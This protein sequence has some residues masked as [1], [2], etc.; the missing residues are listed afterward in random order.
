MDEL[1]DQFL[2]E[3]REL[4]QQAS[5]DLLALERNPSDAARIDSA[6]RAVHTL[7]GSAGI[8]NFGAMGALLHAAEDLLGAV[9]EGQLAATAEIVGTLIDC[10]IASENWI[11]SIENRGELPTDAHVVGRRLRGAMAPHLERVGLIEVA[12]PDTDTGWAQTLIARN[13]K[14]AHAA[15]GA[16]TALR[17]VPAKDCFFLGDD[18]LAM[19]RAIPDLVALDILT[20]EAWITDNF[21]PFVCNLTFEILSAAAIGDIR[22]IFR[23]VPDQ[24]D[25]LEV[26][27][28]ARAAAMAP[29]LI[30]A[31]GGRGGAARTLRVDAGRIDA[32]V[33]FI[34]QLVVAKNALA[35]LTRQAAGID[36]KLARALGANQANIERLTGDMH[37]AVMSMRM[38]PLSRTFQRFPRLVREIASKLGKDVVLTLDGE[39]VEA[40]KSVVDGLFEPLLHILRNAADH[41]IEDADGRRAAQ[42]PRQGRIDLRARQ[43]GDHIVIE[44]TDDGAGVDLQKVRQVAKNRNVMNETAIDALG[45]KAVLDLIFMPGFS[46]ASAVTEV[47]GRG[48]GMDAVRTTIEALGGRV[49]MTTGLGTGSTIRLTLPQAFVINT[50]MTVTVGDEQFGVPIESITE[51]VRISTE[52][53]VPI[54]DG[55]AFVVRDRTIPLLR[56]SDLLG[57]PSNRRGDDVR[58]LIATTAD[59]RVGVE[60]DAFAE[61]VD[62][63]MRPMQGLLSGMPG[64]LGTALLGDGHVLMVLN[65]PELIG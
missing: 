20:R 1:L 46:T 48:V 4:V 50:V 43:L 57:L 27:P 65:L 60:V 36:A 40:D 19:V 39:E 49:S 56:L 11:D 64:M 26:M 22:A 25:V 12:P 33:D 23:F 9:R 7:K 44:V 35:H 58:I 18:P 30:S 45:E 5:D 24:I 17:Y 59:E 29:N 16:L 6:F 32:L 2:I 47:S 37:R 41:G 34:S 61:R 28:D 53:I 51:T 42:K 62:V 31:D 13:R 8:F 14:A 10:I 52:R 15:G 3:G 38:I 21:D 63:L 55:E 54:R